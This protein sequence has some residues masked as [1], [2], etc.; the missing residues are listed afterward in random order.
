MLNLA[1]NPKFLILRHSFRC[2]GTSGRKSDLLP[3]RAIDTKPSSAF[4][5]RLSVGACAICIPHLARRL[6]PGFLILRV[7]P[8][9]MEAVARR[10]RSWNASDGGYHASLPDC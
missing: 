8:R 2:E 6:A 10:L 5:E 4:A 7:A 3:I 9:R 1:L